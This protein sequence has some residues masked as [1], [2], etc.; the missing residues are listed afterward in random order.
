MSNTVK[1]NQIK[2]LC[3]DFYLE[4]EKIVT[5]VFCDIKLTHNEYFCDLKNYL[6]GSSK[7][8]RSCLIFLF[9]QN[10]GYKPNDTDIIKLAAVVEIIHNATLIH[11]DIIDNSPI[12]RGNISLHEKYN[13]KLGVISGDFLLSIAFNLLLNL[14]Q[15]I[16]KNFAECL[17]S[18][19]FGEINQYFSLE[20]TP[21]IDE[22]LKKS[23]QKTSSLFIAALKSLM[24]IKNPEMSL[25]AQKFALHFGRAFQINDDLKNII[26]SDENKPILNDIKQGI[27]TLPVIYALGEA[28]D[29]S[30]IS[31]DEIIKNATNEL[32]IKETKNLLS[33]E[34]NKAI[35]YLK[36]LPENNYKYSIIKLCELFNVN[37]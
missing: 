25:S 20:V 16:M 36:D 21:T 15:S 32:A 11:D 24:E 6:F 19:C 1:Y 12:R 8:I 23:E 37:F 30:L 33:S 5:Q 28:K 29:L 3:N 18:L 10:L 2:N 17:N 7:Q 31:D 4:M 34:L 26:S 9:A 14:P 27:Y 13:N 22:Y 35:S